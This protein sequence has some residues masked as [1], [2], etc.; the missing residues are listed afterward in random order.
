M[1][2]ALPSVPR[3]TVHGPKE[4]GACPGA[5]QDVTAVFHKLPELD[6]L[7]LGDWVAQGPCLGNFLGSEFCFLK[8]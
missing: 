5:A 7:W 3:A 8:T 6:G 4:K 1:S 2:L